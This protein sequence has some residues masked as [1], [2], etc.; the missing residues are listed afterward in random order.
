MT[1]TGPSHEDSLMDWWLHA[2]QNTPT[3]MCKGLGSIALLTS[4][5]IW[6]QRNECIFDGAQPMVHVL[7]SR[8]KDEAQQWA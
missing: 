8:I 4:W 2:R 1:T 5:M 3:P 7:V 6:K